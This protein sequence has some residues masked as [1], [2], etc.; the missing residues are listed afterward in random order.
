MFVF[1]YAKMWYKGVSFTSDKCAL[2]YLVDAAGTRTTTDTF[3]DMNQDFSLPVFYNESRHGPG[4][5]Q[6]V[7]QILQNA[8]YFVDEKN[9]QNWIINNVR[10]SQAP[11]GLLRFE[12]GF[13]RI[14]ELL[15]TKVNY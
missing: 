12:I 14:L 1:R 8:Q 9:V 6:D 5:Q 3:S 13:W 4:Y 10:V 15:F 2:V 11:D 7:M